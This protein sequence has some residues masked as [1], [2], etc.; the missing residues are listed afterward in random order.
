M[1]PSK[2]APRSH[3]V[4]GHQHVNLVALDAVGVRNRIDVMPTLRDLIGD[5]FKIEHLHQPAVDV[6]NGRD[7]R[8]Q[9]LSSCGEASTCFQLM[10]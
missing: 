6:G 5:H 3:R 9:S 8:A 1:I 7:G 4:I 10:R 2:S